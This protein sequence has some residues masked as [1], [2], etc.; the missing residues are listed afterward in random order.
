[1]SKAIDRADK[2]CHHTEKLDEKVGR[3]QFDLVRGLAELTATGTESV[4]P[5]Q[6][7]TY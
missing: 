4:D 2:L 6:E 1:M 3:M 5:Q 7:D